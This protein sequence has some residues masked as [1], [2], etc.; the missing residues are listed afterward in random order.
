[1]RAIGKSDSNSK[2]NMGAA[3]K[4]SVAK[5]VTRVSVARSVGCKFVLRFSFKIK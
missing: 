4:L 1:M 5:S 2:H 3:R